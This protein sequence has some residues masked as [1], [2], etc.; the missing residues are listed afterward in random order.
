MYELEVVVDTLNTD[1]ELEGDM[2]LE[3]VEDFLQLG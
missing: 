1:E 2:M 3:W